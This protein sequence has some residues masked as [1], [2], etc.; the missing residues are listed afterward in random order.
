MKAVKKSKEQGKNGG[1]LTFMLS[2][3]GI[4]KVPKKY[5]F[6]MLDSTPLSFHV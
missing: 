6:T 5:L 3:T 4:Y 1:K 2:C